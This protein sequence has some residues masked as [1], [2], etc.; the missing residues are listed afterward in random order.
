MR[1]KEGPGI[2]RLPA[3]EHGPLELHDVAAPSFDAIYL[4]RRRGFAA[5]AEAPDL[6]L[7]DA[8]PERV[9]EFVAQIRDSCFVQKENVDI[10]GL[11]CRKTCV[12]GCSQLIRREMRPAFEAACSARQPGLDAWNAPD[13]RQ[14]NTTSYTQEVS[15]TR[16]PNA[17]LRCYCDLVSFRAQ[18]FSKHAFRV[19]IPIGRC[20]VE[21]ANTGV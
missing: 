9:E 6:S 5:D 8:L 15:V 7:L 19:P 2:G 12:N 3:P 16:R 13:G 4:R 21:V 10:V 11:Y 14:H 18:R 20:G 17:E 1:N